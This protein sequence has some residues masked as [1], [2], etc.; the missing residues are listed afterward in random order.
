MALVEFV[1]KVIYRPFGIVLGIIAALFSKRVFLWVWSKV[2]DEEPPKPTIR[3]VSWPKVL[4][5]AAV[6]GMVFSTVRAAVNRSGAE[7]W[8][9]LTG[10]WP[11]KHRPEPE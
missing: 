3:E 8:A 9:W 10:V 2:D 6:Q 4:T 11:G 5:A 7:L 1:M